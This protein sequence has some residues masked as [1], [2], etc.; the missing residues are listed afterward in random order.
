VQAR[1]SLLPWIVAFKAVKAT[2]LTSLGIALLVTRH[3]DPVD[4]FLRLALAVHLP[5][6]SRAF[7][8]AF[9]FATHLTIGRQTA[10]GI[11]AFGY[12]VLMGSEGVGLYLR[13]P[14]ARWFTIIATGSLIPLEI[15]EIAR[16][17]HLLRIVVLILNVA[18]VIY[19]YERKEIF[20]EGAN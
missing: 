7:D 2:T 1:L 11:T 12:A 10:L 16:R 4:L 5:V 19:L 3:A 14:W 13:R 9:V 17:V 8:R 20:E 6:T 18:I 15:Y